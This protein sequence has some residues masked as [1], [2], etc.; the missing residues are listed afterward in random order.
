MIFK[1]VGQWKHPLKIYKLHSS[2][3]KIFN[4]NKPKFYLLRSIQIMM[5]QF[6]GIDRT[7][8]EDVASMIHIYYVEGN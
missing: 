4:D 7:Q 1:F 8:K 2:N 3:E 5:L 6:E